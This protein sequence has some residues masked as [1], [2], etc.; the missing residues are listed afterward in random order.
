MFEVERKP[1]D[2]SSLAIPNIL[3]FLAKINGCVRCR[4]G[5]RQKEE[6]KRDREEGTESDGE[7]ESAQ[8]R[9]QE[10]KRGNREG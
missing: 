2:L 5:E 9:E 3:N 7:I 10:R 4:E 8:G 1:V 6:R